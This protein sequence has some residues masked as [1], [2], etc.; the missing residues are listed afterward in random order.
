MVNPFR[1]INP[2]DPIELEDWLQIYR[3]RRLKNNERDVT[4]EEFRDWLTENPTPAADGGLITTWHGTWVSRVYPPGSMVQDD[5]WLMVA[6]KETSDEASPELVGAADFIAP[7]VPAWVDNTPSTTL[8]ISGHRYTFSTGQFISAWRVWIPAISANINYHVVIRDITDPANPFDRI[9]TAI[10][11]LAGA[12]W[13]TVNLAG[14][15][16]G[17]GTVIEFTLLA[18]DDTA[19]TDFTGNWIYNRGTANDIPGAGEIFF[20][21]NDNLLRIHEIDN[22][23]VDQSTDLDTVVVGTVFEFDNGS[24]KTVE[25]IN[26]GGVLYR[27]YVVSN[28]GEPIAGGQDVIGKVPTAAATEYSVLADHWVANQPAFAT[29]VSLFSV[30]G[31]PLTEADELYGVDLETDGVTGSP[32]WDIMATV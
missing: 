10:S 16:F 15:I 28:I 23:A 17:A 31:D 14:V 19:T 5:G 9:N 24:I 13:H 3:P 29:V 21:S 22:N 7:D 26:P 32:D 27:E 18:S 12:A 20:K 6:N 11:P 30:D 8:V 25:S 2:V 1:P 4:L